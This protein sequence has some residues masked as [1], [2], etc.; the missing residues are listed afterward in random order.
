MKYTEQDKIIVNTLYNEGYKI[1]QIS[2]GGSARKLIADD[3]IDEFNTVSGVNSN[4][5]TEAIGFPLNHANQ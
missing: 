2:D 1:Y 4:S 3:K 5:R